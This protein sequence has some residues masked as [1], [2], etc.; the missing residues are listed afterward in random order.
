MSS[1]GHELQKAVHAALTS[2]ASLTGLLG[3]ARVYDDVPRGVAYPYISFGQ[4]T[5]RDWSTGSDEGSE[6]LI[7]LHVWS[8]AHGRREVEGIVAAVRDVLRDALLLLTGFRL[9]NL[10]HE[11]TDAVRDVDGETYHG[12]VRYRAV[13]EPL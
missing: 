10:R 11:I 4:S 13:T 7:T 1:A 9:I 6:H 12:I 3:G 5:E 2:D 8:R